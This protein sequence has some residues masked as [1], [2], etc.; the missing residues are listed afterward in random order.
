MRC[1]EIQTIYLRYKTLKNKIVSTPK[2]S[3][4]YI[5]TGLKKEKQNKQ[6]KLSE[7]CRDQT[8]YLRY[9]TLKNKIKA[10]KI[11]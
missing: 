3:K 2:K 5:E 4:R 1:V 11:I 9:K 10:F 6:T 7:V 8:I